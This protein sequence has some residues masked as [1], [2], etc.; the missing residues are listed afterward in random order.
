VELVLGSLRAQ[1][2]I[3]RLKDYGL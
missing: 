1:A 2:N 3:L